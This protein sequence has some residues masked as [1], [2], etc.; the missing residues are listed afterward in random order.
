MGLVLAVSGGVDGP[1][2]VI[3]KGLNLGFIHLGKTLDDEGADAEDVLFFK[4]IDVFD[5][6]GGGFTR[7]KERCHGVVDGEVGQFCAQNFV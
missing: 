1:H 4:R 2:Y 5:E 7:G 6:G 3:I